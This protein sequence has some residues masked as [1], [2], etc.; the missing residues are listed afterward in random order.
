MND[1]EQHILEVLNID[2][3]EKLFS[4]IPGDLKVKLINIANGISEM[5]LLSEATKIAKKN[6]TGH[7]NFLGNGIYD[8]Y[9]PSSVDSI[10]SRS[11]FLTAYTPYQAEMSQGMLQALF[12][13]QSLISDLTEMDYTNSSMYDGSTALGEA[14]RM[15]YRINGNKKVLLPENILKSHLSVLQNYGSGIDPIFEF[16]KFDSNSGEIDI[17]DL[18]SK[19][20]EDS[21]CIIV[22]NPNCYGIVES[23]IDEINSFK[24]NSLL[25][26]YYDPV[27]LGVLKSPGE[28]GADIA[29]SEGQGLG[30]SQNFGGP[31]L[32]LFSFRK[33]YVRKSPGR[34][35]GKTVDKDGKDAFV[36]TLQTREQHIRRDKATSNICTNQALLSI[37]S[38]IY[39]AIVG[40]KGLKDIALTNFSRARSL[41]KKLEK[42]PGI[43]PYVFKGIFFSDVVIGMNTNN[44]L[45]EKLLE[46]GIVGGK[47]TQDLLQME[48]TK[49]LKTYFFSVTEKRSESDID[50]LVNALEVVK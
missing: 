1:S 43:D 8:R 34:I 9:I 22:Y 18:R 47:S 19:I 13:Y 32:G 46:H 3:A 21:C 14:M 7:I 38:S 45:E 50:L 35:I 11:E 49:N 2:S 31:T 28:L 36:M 15:A 40:S 44:N 39:L 48:P 6:F 30:I 42:I 27:S 23:K 24:G 20:T 29:V 12:E 33:E 4:D 41:Q 37:A 26:Y 25:I 5:E 17:Q 16:Y 10:L